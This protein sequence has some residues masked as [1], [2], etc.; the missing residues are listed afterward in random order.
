MSKR[1]DDIWKAVEAAHGCWARHIKS[2]PVRE[3]FGDKVAWEG[4]VEVFE[5]DGHAKAK[6]CYA[7]S[8]FDKGETQFTTVLEIPPVVSPETAVKVAVAASARRR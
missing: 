3:M 5:I 2:V 6:R 8:Y 4:V 1:I 7:W